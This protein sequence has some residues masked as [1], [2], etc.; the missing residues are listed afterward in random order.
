MKS[1]Y[2][3]G[4]CGSK[5]LYLDEDRV[6]GHRW[7][8]CM[9]CGNRYPGGKKPIRIEEAM[10]TRRGTCTN[11][12][13]ENMVI[14]NGAGHCHTCYEAGKGKEGDA[15]TAA[16]KT[17]KKRVNNPDNTRVTHNHM[18][19]VI[20]GQ[21]PKKDVQEETP[22]IHVDFPG[23]KDID[24]DK[25]VTA[26]ALARSLR[27]KQQPP[28]PEAKAVTLTFKGGDLALHEL[29]LTMA[30]DERRTIDQQILWM[31]DVVYRNMADI[32]RGAA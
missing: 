13:R 24:P 9:T 26:R 12:G 27:E 8:A 4:Q 19:A 17:A 16:L 6:A 7:I 30:R 23:T 29:I 31:V 22:I 3:C 20:V 32:K 15:L 2:K 1:P 21:S 5:T 11:C 10:G 18:R 14:A 25:V 28:D